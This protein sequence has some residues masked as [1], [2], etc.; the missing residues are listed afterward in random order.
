MDFR[1]TYKGGGGPDKTILHSAAQHKK[2]K[3]VDVLVTYLR[4]PADD[5]FQ[6]AEKAHSLG[7]RYIDLVDRKKFD[8]KC[9]LQ[10][11]NLIAAKNIALIHSHDD[12]TLLYSVVLKYLVPGLKIMHTCHSHSEYEKSLF[13]GITDFWKFRVRKKIQIWLM[14]RHLPPVITISDNTRQRLVRGGLKQKNISVL[15]NGIDIDQWSLCNTKPVL[16]EEL[17]LTKGDLLIGTVARITYDKDLP[18]FYEVARR[19]AARLP[20]TRF[21]IVGDGYGSELEQAKNEVAD[22]G[23][24]KIVCFTG[25]RTYLKNIYSS[26]D[27]FLMTSRTEGLPNTVLEAMA[28]EVPVVSTAVG[29]VPEVVIP[30][31][32]GILCPVGDAGSLANTLCA[33]LQQKQ[34]RLKMAKE[35]RK[36]IENTFNFS[37]RVHLL[38]EMYFSYFQNRS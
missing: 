31:K 3:N 16:R 14:Q 9:I 11:K 26:F 1:G 5:E 17:N 27:L 30:G 37:N 25:H 21:V 24:E 18:T 20:N 23:L 2:N 12:K 10:L 38:E 34:Q 13:S 7:I 29:G 32:T 8:L 22:L 28:L 15:Y 6:I 19:V 36:R 35:S 33:L 4:D